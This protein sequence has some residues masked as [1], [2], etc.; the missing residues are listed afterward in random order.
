MI[1]RLIAGAGFPAAHF[2]R[3]VR[4][5]LAGIGLAVCQVAVGRRGAVTGLGWSGRGGRRAAGGF[6]QAG[7]FVLAVPAF[8]QVDGNAPAAVAGGP[9]GDGDQVAAHRGAAGFRVGVAGQGA[10]G[11]QQVA[12]DRRERHPGG[13]R[14]KRA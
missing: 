4:G 5:F 14:R 8:G 2:V 13:V 10:G 1:L 6:E 12:G 9:G 3:R 7:P 11:A